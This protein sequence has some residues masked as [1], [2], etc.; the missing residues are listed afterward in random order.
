[1]PAGLG[2]GFPVIDLSTADEPA[3]GSRAGDLPPD[4]RLQLEDGEYLNLRALQG[5]PVM[6]NFWA[7]WCGPCRLE[8]PDIVEAAAAHEDLVVIAVNVQEDLD[9]VKSFADE[10]GMAMPVALDADGEMRKLYEVRG[11]PTSIFVDR[12]GRISARWDGLLTADLL[13][14]LLAEIL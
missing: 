7:T 12:D 6:I 14:D 4:F 10:F 8:M 13:G 5:R 11:M 2:R 1:L 9:K 3:T